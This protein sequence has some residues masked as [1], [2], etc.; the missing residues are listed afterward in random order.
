MAQDLYK[1]TSTAWLA[2][3]RAEL[4]GILNFSIFHVSQNAFRNV[5]LLCNALMAVP[6]PTLQYTKLM[7][8]GWKVEGA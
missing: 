1:M 4:L 8:S 2:H 7:P 3:G 5:L 6:Q